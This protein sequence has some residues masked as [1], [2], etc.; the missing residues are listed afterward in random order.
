M[1]DLILITLLLVVVI[2]AL[3]KFKPSLFGGG[4]VSEHFENAPGWTLQDPGQVHYENAHGSA[5]PGVGASPGSALYTLNSEWAPVN[6]MNKKGN[7]QNVM[8][9]FK[10]QPEA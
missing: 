4:G 2:F 9:E 3:Y 10:R 8:P 7:P 6:P 1:T 5:P